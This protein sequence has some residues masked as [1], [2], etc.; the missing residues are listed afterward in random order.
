MHTSNSIELAKRLDGHDKIVK[1]IHPNLPSHP[2]YEVAQRIMPR[3]TG[4]LSFVVEGGDEGAM[5]FMSKLNMIFE[6]TSLGGV[7][8]LIEVPATSSHMFV[9]EDVRSEAG[10]IPGFVRMSVGIEDVEDIWTDICNALD[11]S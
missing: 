5:S 6:A 10:V 9:P 3:G 4:M 8:S 7:E 1:V 11:R 2:N